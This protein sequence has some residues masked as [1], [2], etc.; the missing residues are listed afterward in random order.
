MSQKNPFK[1]T[2]RYHILFDNLI[3]FQTV[4]R[5]LNE[6]IKS[7]LLL[8]NKSNYPSNL[9]LFTM[10]MLFFNVILSILYAKNIFA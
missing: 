2:K 7:I 10:D 4:N 1:G 5:P 6:K 8:E 3:V 9:C